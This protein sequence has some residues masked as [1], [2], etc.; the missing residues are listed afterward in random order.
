ML[1]MSVCFGESRIVGSI[2]GFEQDN[3]SLYAVGVSGNSSVEV[4]L[5]PLLPLWLNGTAWSGTLVT[6]GESDPS[7]TGSVIL[8]ARI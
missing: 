4:K 1:G 2:E 8:D 5:S 3:Y 7:T 6:H